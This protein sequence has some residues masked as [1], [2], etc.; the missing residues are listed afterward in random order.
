M[1]FQVIALLVGAALT[2]HFGARA[3]DYMLTR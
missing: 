3:C 2:G 1:L